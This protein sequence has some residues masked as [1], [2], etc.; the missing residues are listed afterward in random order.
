LPP[1][2]ALCDGSALCQMILPLAGSI[3]AHEPDVIVWPVDSE[4]VFV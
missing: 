2:K 3:A 4:R 1:P